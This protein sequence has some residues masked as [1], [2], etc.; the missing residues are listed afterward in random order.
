MMKVKNPIPPPK[1]LR[2]WVVRICHM[3]CL[4]QVG[5]ICN[6]F[7]WFPVHCIGCVVK[8]FPLDKIEQA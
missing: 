3:E 5:H 4:D 8:P 2:R 7:R 6:V 1:G